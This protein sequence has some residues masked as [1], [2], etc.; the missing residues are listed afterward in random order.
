MKQKVPADKN[1][2]YMAILLAVIML[3]SVFMMLFSGSDPT[4]NSNSGNEASTPSAEK[5]S[6]TIPFSQIP[7]KQVHHQFNSIADGLNMS[8]EGVIFAEYVN[9]QNI[10][11]TPLEQS[12]ENT[13]ANL[14]QF[15]GADVTKLYIANYADGSEFELHAIPEQRI[16]NNSFVPVPYHSYYL[17]SRGSSGD[18][19][20]VLGSPVVLG[21][22]QT[23]KNVIDV[24]EGNATSTTQYNGILNQ[25][26][27]ENVII[28][29]VAM[30]TNYTTEAVADQ[31]Y[32]DLLKQDDGSYAQTSLFMNLKPDVAKNITA[33]QTTSSERGV[34]YNITSSGNITKLVISSDFNS[35]LNETRMLK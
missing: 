13:T 2:K 19:W 11:G 16:L 21:S 22:R 8:P 24:L 6:S 28:Q 7:G 1:K 32:M 10:K 34:K 5:K 35:L 3:F 26:N 17:L 9:I 12:Y 30:K 20:N 27:P 33:L 23:V 4:A 15:Y 31:Y 14:K 25:T 29:E 18:A